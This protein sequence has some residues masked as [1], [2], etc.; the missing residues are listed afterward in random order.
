MSESTSE[1]KVD[2]VALL[3]L[4]KEKIVTNLKGFAVNLAQFYEHDIK[5]EI[6]VCHDMNIVKFNVTEHN[7]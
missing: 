3:K 4:N 2:Y 1:Y 6:N 5:I 7:L